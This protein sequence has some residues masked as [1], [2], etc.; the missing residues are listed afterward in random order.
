MQS[1]PA[2]I[3]TGASRGLGYHTAKTLAQQNIAVLAVARDAQKLK[4]LA[5]EHTNIQT[6]ALDLTA[7]SA[8]TTLAQEAK[9][10]FTALD[11]LINNA[12]ILINKPIEKTSAGDFRATLELNVVVPFLLAQA[13]LPLLKAASKP[14]II[15]IG[16]MGGVQ[17]SAKFPG[18]GAYSA[19]KGAL[20]VLTE[21][22]AEEL[23]EVGV[24]T[25]CLALGAA[26]TEMLSAAFPG[27]KAPVTAQQMAEYIASFA[28]S[29][30]RY[31]NG[32]V[33]PVSLSTP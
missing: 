13:L 4:K 9:K 7:D 10:R 29:G 21:C 14:H 32:K 24:C 31:Y 25:N 18:L 8:I 6:I 16:S 11:I 20:A 23:K 30:H 17:G 33:L 1:T 15:N 5:A 3:V 2:A 28:I 12:G 22:M 26:Q 27:F 19:S